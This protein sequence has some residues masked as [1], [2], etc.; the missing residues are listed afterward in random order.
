MLRQRQSARG[1]FSPLE[2]LKTKDVSQDSNE[3]CSIPAPARAF[4]KYYPK[5]QQERRKSQRRQSKSKRESNRR[6]N[7]LH[8]AARSESKDKLGCLQ[9]DNCWRFP[10]PW[11]TD[12]ERHDSDDTL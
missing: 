4:S 6:E 12:P 2:A 10:F 8:Q 11:T 9:D 1:V 3:A 5:K 7:S